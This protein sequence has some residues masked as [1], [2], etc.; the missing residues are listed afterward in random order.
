MNIAIIAGSNRQ[1]S[2]S[3]RLARYVEEVIAQQGHTVSFYDPKQTP[4]PFFSTDEDFAGH[5]GLA[6]LRQA[7]SDAD[8]IVLSTPEYHG[9]VSG[10]LKNALDFLGQPHFE[11]KTVLSMSSAGGAVGIGSLHQ[12]HSIVRSLHGV[13]CPE[14]ISVSGFQRDLPWGDDKDTESGRKLDTRIRVAVNAFLGMATRLSAR[15]SDRTA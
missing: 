3:T 9:A 6:A 4:L 5:S 12:L 14:W 7:V 1:D 8:A 11:G 13:N 10:V 15:S 2:N